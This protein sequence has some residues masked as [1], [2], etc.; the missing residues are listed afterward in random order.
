M[1][2]DYLQQ[3]TTRRTEKSDIA[4]T[5]LRLLTVL[6]LLSSAAASSNAQSRFDEEYDEPTKAWQEIAIQ[7]PA[8]P[9]AVNLVAFYVSPIATQTFTLDTRSLTVGTDGVIRYTMVSTSTAGAKN[10]SYEGIRC[11]TLEKRL[12]AFGQD[13][14]TWSR[15][16][17]N[18]W[19][20]VLQTVANRRHA[21]LAQD[22][23]CEGGMVAG[24]AEDIIKRLINKQ[25]FSPA[26][27]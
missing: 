23:F 21:A 18:Q 9:L 24:K 5:A 19:E 11:Q 10:I 26:T 13:D 4:G 1:R 12:Y 16:R 3:K 17:N 15:S 6:A 8:A 22:Y 2:I 14:G 25:A 20:K 27:D 7:R